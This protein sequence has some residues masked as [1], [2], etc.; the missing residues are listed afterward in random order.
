MNNL[1]K[2][3]NT[4]PSNKNPNLP[5]DVIPKQFYPPE[6]KKSLNWSAILLAVGLY[7]LACI[8]FAGK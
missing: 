1:T 3:A 6:L 8:W 5:T 7:T 2:R 4:K